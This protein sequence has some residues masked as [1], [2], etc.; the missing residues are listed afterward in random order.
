MA[1]KK[2]I[3]S[4]HPIH[5]GSSSSSSNPSNSVKFCDEKAWDVLF[6]NFSNRVIHL[7]C[8]VILS[9]FLDTPLPSAFSS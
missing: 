3:P 6:E 4:K 9:N 5:H 2:S 7:E 8:Q 1:P